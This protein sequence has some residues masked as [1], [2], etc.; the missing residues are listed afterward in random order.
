MSKIQ[1]CV[2]YRNMENSGI[3]EKMTGLMDILSNNREDIKKYRPL[4]FQ[5][6]NELVETAA[7]YGF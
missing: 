3:L 6:V 5:C 7:S 1:E 4:F 2:L